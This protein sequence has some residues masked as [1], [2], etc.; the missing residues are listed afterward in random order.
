MPRRSPR[1]SQ[2]LQSLIRLYKEETGTREVDMKAVARW[3]VDRGMREPK[4]VSGVD[5]LAKEFSVAARQETRVD[6]ETGEPYRVNHMYWVERDGEQLR[7]WGDIDELPR[8]RMQ[9]SLTIRREQTVSDVTQLTIDAEHWNR[10]NPDD[11]RIEIEKDFG[12]DVEI[13]RS[14]PARS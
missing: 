12:L 4:P 6:R 1:K 13:R 2:Q 5:R 7:L 8:E 10:V 9:A 11:E 14:S 3:A